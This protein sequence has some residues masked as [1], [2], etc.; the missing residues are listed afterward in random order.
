MSACPDT[1][2]DLTDEEAHAILLP[3]FTAVQEQYLQYGLDRCART[4]LII[5]PK[6]HD[7]NRHFAA[8]TD[9]GGTIYMAPEL[10]ELPLETVFAV[11]AH[12]LGHACD[13]LYPGQFALRGDDEPAAWRDPAAIK[14]RHWRRG[15]KEWQGR[16]DDSVE[17]TADAIAHLVMGVRYGYRGPCLIQSFAAMRLRPM[18]LR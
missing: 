10:A 16:D 4:R 7:T 3:C 13:F 2:T 15:L 14:E 6:M 11:A 1:A 17:L 8:C 5:D 18:G 12:E 9:D